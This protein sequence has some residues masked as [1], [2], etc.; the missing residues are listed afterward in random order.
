MTTRFHTPTPHWTHLLWFLDRTRGWWFVGLAVLYAAGFNGQWLITPDSAVHVDAARVWSEGG[1]PA[2]SPEMLEKIQPGLGLVLGLV[3]GGSRILSGD[4]WP[5]SLLMLGFAAAVLVL[6]YRLMILHA[7]RPTAVLMV[8]LLGTNKL[9]YSMSLFLLTEMPFTV[10]LVLL[11][12]GH[13]RRLKLK[14]GLPVSLAMMAAGVLVMA[15]FRSVAA[16]VVAGYLLAELTRV[17]GRRDQR[18][19]GLILIGVGAA[20]GTMLWIGSSAVRDDVSIFENTLRSITLDHLL[21]NAREFYDAILPEAAAGLAVPP[22][23]SWAVTAAVAGAGLALLRVRWLW[24][25]LVSVFALQWLVF[26]PDI[27]YALPLLPV[28]IYGGWTLLIAVASRLPRWPGHALFGFVTF[29]V[30]AANLVGIGFTIAEQRSAPF[31]DAYRN[32][33]YAPVREIAEAVR[34]ESADADTTVVLTSRRVWPELAAWSGRPAVATVDPA[35][36]VKPGALVVLPLAELPRAELAEAGLTWGP[37]LAE[38]HDP[39]TGETWALHRLKNTEP[40]GGN[41]L[42]NR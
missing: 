25:V 14:Q 37:A 31:Y 38:A 21:T 32:G 17:V 2:V 39:L 26:L 15:A 16:V 8:L 23:F 24:A 6:T 13:E 35:A 20:A 12:W 1:E 7:D 42:K 18:R 4:G 19:L 34:R 22:P 9:F 33:K 10:G 29:C 28:V 27:R 3:G 41:G 30:V 36:G 40:H 5:T 11:L